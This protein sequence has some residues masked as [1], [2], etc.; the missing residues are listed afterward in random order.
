MLRDV[1]IIITD[2]CIFHLQ[3][4]IDE[5]TV[6]YLII[7]P[8]H[9]RSYQLEVSSHSSSHS[10]I[11]PLNIRPQQCQLRFQKL[12]NSFPKVPF[13]KRKYTA[14]DFA[15]NSKYRLFENLQQKQKVILEHSDRALPT[16]AINVNV[17]PVIK[18]AS[19]HLPL[20][21]SSLLFS[22]Q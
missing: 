20:Y 12:T 4:P 15:V 11:S 14:A 3:R 18:H 16:T 19:A 7:P 17:H 5:P 2:A 6:H 13:C 9:Q 8:T 1:I 21:Y 10:T 22:Y